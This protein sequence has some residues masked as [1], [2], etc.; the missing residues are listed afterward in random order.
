M[1]ALS[2]WESLI[3]KHLDGRTNEE[4]AAVLSAR[5]VA[6][7]DVR[8][9]YLKA[10]Q[11]HGALSNELV[12]LDL[13]EGF[14][15]FS[16]PKRRERSVQPANWRNQ[17]AASLVAGA[18]V[19]LVG[20]GMVWAMAS[21]K[22][23]ASVF[24]I[25]HGDFESLTV[26]PIPDQFPVRFGEWNGDPAEVSVQV[27]GNRELR[28]LETA[29]ISRLPNGPA[30]ACDVFQ[31]VDLRSL[32]QQWDTIDPKAE[33]TLE[34]AARF[35]RDAQPPGAAART[36]KGACHL[37]LFNAAPETIGKNWPLALSG[38]VALGSK[39]IKLVPGQESVPVSASCF[40]APEA[41]VAVIHVAA[42]PKLED[43]TPTT[44]GD[45]FVDDVQLT[46]TRRPKLPVRLVKQ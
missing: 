26:G 27:N 5:I 42:N 11:L 2:D 16:A 7:V 18:L 40:L 34:L 29:N 30:A 8:S 1:T 33:L 41:T 46:L 36:I 14:M 43:R 6:D 28:F 32:R 4:E 17:I 45:C 35:R 37:Y 12:S 31:L 25:A 24:R 23:V 3:Q 13:E 9:R 20:V 19:G 21:P 10:A 39:N 15:E 38:A 22:A 44:L